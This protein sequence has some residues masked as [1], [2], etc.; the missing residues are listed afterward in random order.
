MKILHQLQIA[1]L[2]VPVEAAPPVAQRVPGQQGRVPAEAVEVPEALHVA[3]AVSEKVQVHG[4]AAPGPDPLVLRHQGALAVVQHGVAAPGQQAA[5]QLRRAV[6]AVQ[7][8]GR[9]L[10][11]PDG[12]SVPPDGAVDVEALLQPHGEALRGKGLL[13]V[14]EAEFFRNDL[15]PPL[16]LNDLEV[17]HW[18]VP[19][20]DGLCRLVRKKSLRLVLHADEGVRQDGEPPA[21]PCDRGL[22]PG[23]WPQLQPVVVRHDG[24]LLSRVCKFID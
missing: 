10:Q 24:A 20:K 14:A 12:V 11:V 6:H 9:A 3:V 23:L 1:L 16:L 2:R 13:V 8:P 18:E 5:L 15:Q 4:L 19:A 7:G 21:V 22:R 17:R